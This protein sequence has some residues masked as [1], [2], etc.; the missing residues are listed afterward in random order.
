MRES[1]LET[2]FLEFCES[3]GIMCEKL[4]PF[5]KKGWPD[6]TLMYKGS[7]MFMELKKEGEKPDP[8]QY[9][10]LTCL[11]SAGFV[12]VWADNLEDAKLHVTK[13]KRHVDDSFNPRQ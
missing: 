6:R 8:I 9:Y 13:W 11:Q 1:D 10:W 4:I 2:K 3:L 12:A 7:C 5:A